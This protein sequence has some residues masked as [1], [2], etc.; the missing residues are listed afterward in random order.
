MI[1]IIITIILIIIEVAIIKK[2]YFDTIKSGANA[3][4]LQN[5]NQV[6]ESP[7]GTRP[8]RQRVNNSARNLC[9]TEWEQQ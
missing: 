1:I 8:P 2:L 4:R 6:P 9:N 3:E 7:E 5:K